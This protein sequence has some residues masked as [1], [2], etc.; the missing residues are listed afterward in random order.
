MLTGNQSSTYV[1]FANIDLEKEQIMKASD[2]INKIPYLGDVA[3][4]VSTYLSEHAIR[5]TVSAEQIVLLEG[6]TT[7]AIFIVESGGLKAVQM[8]PTGREQVLHFIEAGETFNEISVLIESKNP[9]TV[10]ALEESILWKINRSTVQNMLERHPATAKIVIEHL[11]RRFQMLLGI[12]EDLS[13]RTI[14]ARLANFLLENATDDTMERAK[15]ATQAALANRL[16]TVP[17]VLH[18]ALQTLVKEELI[19]VERR[20]ITILDREGLL[21]RSKLDK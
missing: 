4:T 2:V 8:S 10:I 21:L 9:V 16:G 7:Q 12:I 11:A 18:R 6:E 5:Q 15:W 1:E 20:K 3:D 13:L 19:L 14:E 17:D